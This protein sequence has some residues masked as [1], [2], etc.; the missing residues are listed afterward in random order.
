MEGSRSLSC[1]PAPLCGSMAARPTT[2]GFTAPPGTARPAGRARTALVIFGV[3]N[4]PVREGFSA[5]AP[6]TPSAVTSG[7]TSAGATPTAGAT[8]AGA[9]SLPATVASGAR[10]NVRSGPGTGYPVISTVA[11]GAALTAAARN[12]A[13]DWIRVQQAALPGGSGWV[14]ARFLMEGS[15]RD[16]LSPRRLPAQASA[17]RPQPASK[18]AAVNGLDR[19]AGLPGAQRRQDLRVRSGDRQP[20]CPHHGRGPGAQPGRRDG[21]FLA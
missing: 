13:G 10:L 20:A 16:C 11:P 18:A 12:A 5:P 4:V 1:R 19:Q 21:G 7:A 17:A 9:T 6:K 15:A 3:S 14:S 8:P 2:A